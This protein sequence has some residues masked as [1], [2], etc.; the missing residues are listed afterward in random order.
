MRKLFGV[1]ALICFILLM[2]LV[3]GLEQDRIDFVLGSILVLIDAFAFGAFVM[4]AA[5][6]NE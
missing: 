4:F 5:R 6:W 3:G 2:G 1:C